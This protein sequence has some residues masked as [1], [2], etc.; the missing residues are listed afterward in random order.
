[1]RTL[2]FLP[3]AL[4]G[5]CASGA[6]AQPLEPAARLAFGDLALEQPAGRA[7]LR[8]RV[9]TAAHG[10]CR[11][12]EDEVTPQ[13]LQSDRFYCLEQVRSTLVA[14]MP[15]AVRRAYKQALREAGVSGRRL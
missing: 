15:P 4:L 1:M 10:F 6:S 5:A 13:L 8:A 7:E 2:F 14:D 9:A 11:H 3:F 12:H